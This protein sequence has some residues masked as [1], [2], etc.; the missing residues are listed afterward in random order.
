MAVGF[1]V[2]LRKRHQRGREAARSCPV[3]AAFWL[4]P[5]TG[6]AT[7]VGAIACGAGAAH[8]QLIGIRFHLVE[9][10]VRPLAMLLQLRQRLLD[11]LP[12]SDPRNSCP[13]KAAF[14]MFRS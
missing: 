2:T 11:Q 3:E 1:S 4:L 6:R 5:G 12:S 14:V 10:T 7:L 8:A 9:Q 13:A